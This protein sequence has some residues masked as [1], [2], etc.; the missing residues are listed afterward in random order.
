MSFETSMQRESRTAT[1]PVTS[2]TVAEEIERRPGLTI[3]ACL[4]SWSAL[5]HLVRP[6]MECLAFR[7]FGR[8]RF[9]RVD[10]DAEPTLAAH[11]GV[12]TVPTVLFFRD[13]AL[14]E[15]LVGVHRPSAYEGT[16][17]QYA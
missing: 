16:I 17:A 12:R 7:H 4:A 10:I 3:V 6:I 13:G 5:S 15:R 8:I 11:L 2:S 1:V 9:A 14:V